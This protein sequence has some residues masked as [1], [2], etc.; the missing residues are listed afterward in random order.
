MTEPSPFPAAV[1]TRDLCVWRDGAL[2]VDAVS[3]TLM[4][5]EIMSLVGPSGAGKSSLLL[6]LAGLIDYSGQ[7]SIPSRVGVVFQDH[8]VFPWLTVAR[9]VEYGLTG[10]TSADRRMRVDEMLAMA[11]IAEFRER[12]PAQLSGG[13]RQRVA[14]ARA[15]ATRPEF[16]LLDEPFASLDILTRAKLADW[17]RELTI[18]LRLPTLM[19]S[20]DLDEALRVADR[21]SIMVDGRLTTL[22]VRDDGAEDTAATR[23]KILSLMERH[24]GVMQ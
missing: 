19:V 21:I 8:G 4:P 15:L 11:D 2:V 6:A 10:L 5:G 23:A 22:A 24:E 3:L 1:E 7:V 9:N 16:I 18:R 14:V 13:Q 20:H 12:Y 17:L